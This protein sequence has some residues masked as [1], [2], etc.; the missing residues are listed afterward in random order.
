MALKQAARGGEEPEDDR[1]SLGERE[2][3]IDDTLDRLWANAEVLADHVDAVVQLIKAHEPEWIDDLGQRR[4]QAEETR[5]EAE[6]ML[7]RA[8]V[9]EWGIH[10]TAQCLMGTADDRIGRGQPAPQPG[11]PPPNFT[12]ANQDGPA[13]VA[14]ADLAI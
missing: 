11:P 4:L 8:K 6:R 1:T 14:A 10:T 9:A 2:Q 7:Q 3:V 12:E 13:L 5:L